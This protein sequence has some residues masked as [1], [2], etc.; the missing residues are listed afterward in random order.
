[1]ATEVTR[2]DFDA[3]PTGV[4]ASGEERPVYLKQ[5]HILPAVTTWEEYVKYKDDIEIQFNRFDKDGNGLWD[6]HELLAFL[7]N[8]LS[9]YLFESQTVIRKLKRLVQNHM[10]ALLASGTDSRVQAFSEVADA[11]LSYVVRRIKSSTGS[12]SGI[13]MLCCEYMVHARA[14]LYMQCEGMTSGCISEKLEN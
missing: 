6:R 14:D 7:D 2:S 3:Q 12:A 13:C 5:E 10:S 8:L 4:G 9:K 11:F 1:M